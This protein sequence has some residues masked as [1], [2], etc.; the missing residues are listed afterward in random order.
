[1]EAAPRMVWGLPLCGWGGN[2]DLYGTPQIKSAACRDFGGGRL[3]AVFATGLHRWNSMHKTDATPSHAHRFD[4]IRR[5]HH[6]HSPTLQ[7]DATTP[8]TATTTPNPN[9]KQ[10]LPSSTARAQC[11][12]SALQI[13]DDN[14]QPLPPSTAR[15]QFHH[16]APQH[17]DDNTRPATARHPPTAATALGGPAGGGAQPVAPRR[18]P[19]E[20]RPQRR[21]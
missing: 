2:N 9:N 6:H 13:L 7:T 12:R 20:R 18:G 5:R 11:R 17:L 10:P 8:A 14:T 15:A 1:M 19:D 21:P 3:A 4:V 16:S